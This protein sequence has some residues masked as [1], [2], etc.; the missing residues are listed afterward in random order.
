MVSI[1]RIAVYD[2]D[3]LFRCQIGNPSALSAT[4][5]HNL[6]STLNITVPLAH[7]RLPELMT[8]GARLKVKFKGRH[9][10]S[11]PI[12]SEAGETDGVSGQ[13]TFTVED[14]FRIL[15]D[16][17]GWQVPGS[18]IS[19][20]SAAEYRTYTGDA[21]TIIKTAVAEN[22]I[23]RL[24]IP[25]LSV[26]PN[27]HRGGVVP[28]G[29]PLRMHPLAD[30]MFP[31]MDEAG[32]GVTVRQ[33]GSGLV[34]DVYEPQ[35]YPRKLS[36]KG[37]TLK[38][39]SWTKTRPESSRVVIGGQG[40]GTERNFRQVIDGARESQYGMR[41][42]AFRD[43]RD[44]DA[45]DVMDDRGRETLSETAAKNGISLD[46][47]GTG[48]FQYGPGG[49]REG[50]RVPV[51]LGHGVLMTETIREVTLNWVSKD[52]A[53]IQPSIGEI[54]TQPARIIAQRLA[55]LAKGVRNQELI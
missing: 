7:E 47:V 17:L 50:D 31:A 20:Q 48:I 53:S 46:L 15:R 34:L 30:K 52:Y 9:L 19:N 36:V 49:F 54:S 45:S 18:P 11:G 2:K 33:I 35:L 29:V 37:R 41:A 22:G 26:A 1:F 21:E 5:R 3:R 4:V 14:D 43:A 42:E 44:N 39:A 24:A 27:L 23:T 38:K 25:G 40:E 6:V 16:I 51:N 55:A 28:G 8:D 12:V 32:I 10:I 13:V